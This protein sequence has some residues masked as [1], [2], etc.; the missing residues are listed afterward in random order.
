MEDE[1][2][3]D[4]EVGSIVRVKGHQTITYRIVE[5]NDRLRSIDAVPSE[6]WEDTLG[7]AVRSFAA[8]RLELA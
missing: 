4:L 1:G 7:K 8:E 2:P 6:D 3:V 5:M